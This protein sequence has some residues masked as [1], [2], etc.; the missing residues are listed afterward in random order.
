MDCTGHGTCD[1]ASGTC[2]CN[3]GFAGKHAPPCLSNL[4]SSMRHNAFVLHGNLSARS[5]PA[6]S[7]QL[8]EHHTELIT[9]CMQAPAA[10][11][12][13]LAAAQQAHLQPRPCVSRAWVSAL[14]ACCAVPLASS[15]AMGCAVHQVCSP[16]ASLMPLLHGR[17]LP[18]ESQHLCGIASWYSMHLASAASSWGC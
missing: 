4:W 1:A 5:P 6:R 2:S 9:S 16:V 13:P 3:S 15:T 10:L 14:Q 17:E 11:Y 12:R 18:A 8:G 7:H